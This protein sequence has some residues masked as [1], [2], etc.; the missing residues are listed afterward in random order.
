MFLEQIRYCTADSRTPMPTARDSRPPAS[1]GASTASAPVR[2]VRNSRQLQGYTITRLAILQGP[3]RVLV[4]SECNLVVVFVR[5][6]SASG[7]LTVCLSWSAGP[8]IRKVRD[9]MRAGQI[10]SESAVTDGANSRL[11]AR[12]AGAR[13]NII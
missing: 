13:R 7:L 5:R 3:C 4:E 12:K 2:T 6:A 11:L 10:L 8:P 9:M 1:S